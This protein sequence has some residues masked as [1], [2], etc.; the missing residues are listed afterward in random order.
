VTRR[1]VAFFLSLF[2]VG[3]GQLFLGRPRRALG[4]LAFG[5][6]G[7]PIIASVVPAASRAGL[8]FVVFVPLVVT[9]LARPLSAVDAIAIESNPERSPGGLVLGAAFIV[10]LGLLVGSALGVRIFLLEAF[11]V[12][13]GSMMPTLLVDDHLFVDKRSKGFHRGRLSVFQFPE[14]P[15]QD[16]VKRVIAVGGDRLEMRHGHPWINGWEVPHCDVGHGSL[17]KGDEPGTWEGEVF[18][19]FLEDEAYLTLSDASVP[20]VDE[21]PW[22]VPAGQAFVLGDNR[23]NSYDSRRWFNNAGGGVP[24]DHAHGEPVVIWM[25]TPRGEG[26]D[27]S[28]F[29]Q[30]LTKPTLPRGLSALRPAFDRCLA[31]R[32]PTSAT[33]PPAP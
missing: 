3:V 18:V 15:S 26:L 14:N 10:S 29:G 32:P 33:T 6:L 7:A 28:R 9:M 16:F 19:E 21:G 27:W 23:D 31:S 24:A 20:A 13:A 5:V 12:P 17:P 1:V 4:W 25:S 22:T 30:V 11:K 2:A 8:F